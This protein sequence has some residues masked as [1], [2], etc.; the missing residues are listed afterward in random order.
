MNLD[1]LSFLNIYVGCMCWHVHV[2]WCMP[3]AWWRSKDNLCGLML[4]FF[5]HVQSDSSSDEKQ[6]KIVLMPEFLENPWM[7]VTSIVN[8]PWLALL[9]FSEDLMPQKDT[10]KP[11]GYKF[12]LR[13]PSQLGVAAHVCNPR[14]WKL[15]G[16]CYLRP[17]PSTQWIANRDNTGRLYLK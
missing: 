14:L 1:Q 6:A 10:C 5:Y 13:R 17:A 9:S 8:S 11:A 7:A 15:Q 2:T 12:L 16:G 4:F 3:L